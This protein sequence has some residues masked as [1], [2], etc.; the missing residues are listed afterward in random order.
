LH[1]PEARELY[2]GINEMQPV[3]LYNL[4][5]MTMEEVKDEPGKRAPTGHKFQGKALRNGTA[6]NKFYISNWSL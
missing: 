6:H 2:L 1:F 4:A 5:S 3:G